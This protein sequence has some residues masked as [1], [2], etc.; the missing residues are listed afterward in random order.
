MRIPVTRDISLTRLLPN[1]QQAV[2]NHLADPDIAA[3]TVGIPHPFGTHDFAEKL[4]RDEETESRF[5]HPLYLAVRQSNGSLIGMIGFH[6]VNCDG[7]L[8]VGYWLGKPWWGQGIMTDA[9]RAACSH[10]FYVSDLGVVFARAFTTNFASQRVLEKVGFRR[11]GP[12]M[13]DKDGHEIVGWR[14]LLTEDLIEPPF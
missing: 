11:D 10:A 9:V 14:Y 7:V 5:G 13:F 3:T 8:E 12:T 1:D 4:A 2:L 6:E